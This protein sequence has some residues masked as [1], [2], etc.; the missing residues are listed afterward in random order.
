VRVHAGDGVIFR[1]AGAGGWGDPLERDPL[2]TRNDVARRLMS[3]AKAREEYGV[4]LSGPALEVDRRA[5]D[6]LRDSMRRNRKTP[7]LFDFGERKANASTS[8]AVN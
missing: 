2:R 7:K 3:E 4:I 5:T 1:T 8:R 6:E